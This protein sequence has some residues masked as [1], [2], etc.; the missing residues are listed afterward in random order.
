M[1]ND[2][3]GFLTFKA[4][5]AEKMIAFAM[6]NDHTCLMLPVDLEKNFRFSLLS[7]RNKK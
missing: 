6:L 2:K 5:N 7:W 3:P 1:L 4:N